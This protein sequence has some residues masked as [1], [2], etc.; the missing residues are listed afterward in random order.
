MRATIHGDRHDAP[1]H[2]KWARE[3]F[4]TLPDV[5]VFIIDGVRNGAGSNGYTGVNEVRLRNG[6][7]VREGLHTTLSDMRLRKNA[8]SARAR[9]V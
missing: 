1:G 9:W 5:R 4:L 8:R 7:V 3:C 6:R 2:L